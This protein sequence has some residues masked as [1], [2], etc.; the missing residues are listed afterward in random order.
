MR[1]DVWI[2]FSGESE[3]LVRDAAATISEVQDSW[4]LHVDAQFPPNEVPT[5]P[6]E[7]HSLALK[8]G[9][10]TTNRPLIYVT[11]DSF[12]DKWFS[13]EFRD[14]SVISSFGVSRLDTG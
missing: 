14:V 10:T 4:L 5:V 9:E 13:H 8:V 7:P 6:D 2:R 11:H 12:S 3:S 1:R